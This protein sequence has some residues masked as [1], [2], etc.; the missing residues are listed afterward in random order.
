[1]ASKEIKGK[2]TELR[3]DSRIIKLENGYFE[4]WLED[5]L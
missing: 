1:M 3:I 5:L 2:Y 4:K